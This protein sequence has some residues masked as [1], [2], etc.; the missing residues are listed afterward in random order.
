VVA[1]G[2]CFGGELL[3]RVHVPRREAGALRLHPSLEARRVGEVEAAQERPEVERD[4]VG[5][6]AARERRVEL[7]DV[8]L[9]DRGVEAER[10][11]ADERRLAERAPNG[12]QELLQRVPAGGRGALGPQRGDEL[13]ARQAA[14]ARGGE[15]REEREAPP[16]LPELRSARADQREPAE[17]LQT[18]DEPRRKRG[19]SLG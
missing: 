16:L 5:E 1:R 9:D 4:R 13:I 18:Q 10:I 14:I 7:G 17:R 19:L 8:A 15:Q 2:G 12:V 3:Q 6:R 11:G